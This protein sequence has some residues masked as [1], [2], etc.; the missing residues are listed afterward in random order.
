MI[1]IDALC[2]IGSQRTDTLPTLAAI[3]IIDSDGVLSTVIL[4]IHH[5]EGEVPVGTLPI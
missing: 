4:Y 5:F 1:Y 2:L 3:T